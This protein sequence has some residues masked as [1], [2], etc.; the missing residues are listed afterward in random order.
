VAQVCDALNVVSQTDLTSLSKQERGAFL[1]NTYH[2]L[3]I[4]LVTK[5]YDEVQFPG[6]PKLPDFRSILN[7]QGLGQRVWTDLKWHVAGAYRS[8]AEIEHELL[9][10]LFGPDVHLVLQRGI[11]GFQKNH[12]T[13]FTEEN[14]QER[15]NEA[16]IDFVNR[17]TF[18]D[19][20][21]AEDFVMITS[22]FIQ[23]LESN[24]GGIRGYLAKHLDKDIVGIEI[25]S[26]DLFKKIPDPLDLGVERFLWKLE[27]EP[28]N[29]SINEVNL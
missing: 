2:L 21:E 17:V 20:G 3:I 15:L 25:D 13:V 16:A 29:W 19:D 6:K 11:S 18:F 28:I 8:L 26:D 10:P 7:I 12:K 24:F 4:H 22:E 23:I 27:S 5:H 14:I 9:F 1:I